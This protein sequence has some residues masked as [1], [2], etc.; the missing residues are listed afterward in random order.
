M[1]R[2]LLAIA[3][4][5]AL[6]V[7]TPAFAQSGRS[8]SI[9]TVYTAVS[10]EDLEQ[11]LTVEGY[12]FERSVDSAGDPLFRI[13]IEGLKVVLIFNACEEG[14]CQNLQLYTG[15]AMQEKPA[16]SVV[17]GWNKTKR[18]GRAYIDDEADP[19]LESDLDLEGGVSAGA[20]AEFIRTFT[21]LSTAFAEHIGY[22]GG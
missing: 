17:N 14:A 4:P 13:E 12:T 6:L 18:F 11:I 19:V 8:T 7:A 1:Y 22:K 20:V 2:I 21:V 16:L 5:L 15:F 10:G 9:G 3:V